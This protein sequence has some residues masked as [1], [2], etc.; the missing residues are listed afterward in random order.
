MP[1][2]CRT[3]RQYRYPVRVERPRA[4]ATRDDGGHVDLTDD[5][6]WET[7]CE[8]H[9]AVQASSGREFTLGQQV[10]ADTDYVLTMPANKLTLA[11]DATMRVVRKGDGL[12]VNLTAA[13]PAG[14]DGREVAMQGRAAR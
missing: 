2:R 8:G 4:G 13:Y 7:H 12:T 11:V 9:A 1:E 14:E 6:N 5:A 10:M 3:S